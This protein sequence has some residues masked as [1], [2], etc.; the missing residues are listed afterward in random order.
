MF[1]VLLLSNLI[2]TDFDQIGNIFICQCCNH[3]FILDCQYGEL[4]RKYHHRTSKYQYYIC[5]DNHRFELYT[6]P[7]GGIFE[8][9]TR[10]CQ[11]VGT[12]ENLCTTTKPCLNGSTC[13]ALEN[14]LYRCVC[15]QNYYAYNCQIAFDSCTK[16]VCGANSICHSVHIDQYKS[17]Y[18]CVYDNNRKYGYDYSKGS[19]LFKIK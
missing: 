15:P 2:A 1:Y 7:S 4:N 18:I 19:S 13:I 3:K 14:D 8:I 12:N 17:D 6:C 11:S 16:N 5:F 10:E 9:E